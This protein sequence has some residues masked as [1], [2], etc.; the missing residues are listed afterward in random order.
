MMS[1]LRIQK[2]APSCLG[3]FFVI[4][5]CCKAEKFRS[6]HLLRSNVSGASNLSTV[7]KGKLYTFF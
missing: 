2:F 5:T 3:S 6:F 7:D 4:F 1:D